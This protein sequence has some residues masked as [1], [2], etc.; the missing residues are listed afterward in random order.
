MDTVW[1]G[2]QFKMREIDEETGI[3][4]EWNK[5]AFLEILMGDLN[6]PI[7][8]HVVDYLGKGPS[9]NNVNDTSFFAIL[10]LPPFYFCHI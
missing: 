6:V 5:E 9:I 8:Y 4:R 2:V 7:C 10:D 1:Q 3:E